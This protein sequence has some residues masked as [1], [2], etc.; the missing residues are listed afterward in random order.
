M[1]SSMTAAYLESV[2]NEH[3]SEG[4]EF[5]RV[6]EVGVRVNPGCLAGLFGAPVQHTVYYVVTFRQWVE[7]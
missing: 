3:S 2:V 1:S 5:C 4:W 7:V 6:D